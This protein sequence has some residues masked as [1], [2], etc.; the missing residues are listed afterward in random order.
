VKPEKIDV[1]WGYCQ[2]LQWS[3]YTGGDSETISATC[4]HVE[5]EAGSEGIWLLS[6]SARIFLELEHR[7][8][9][10]PTYLIIA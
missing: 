10:S 4:A 9:R 7:V 1:S 2:L 6:Y 3:T 8:S 5:V